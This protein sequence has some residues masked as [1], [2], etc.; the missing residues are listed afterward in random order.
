MRQIVAKLTMS[1]AAGGAPATSPAP[2]PSEVAKAPGRGRVRRVIRL[3]KEE[4]LLVRQHAAA[5]GFSMQRW[6]VALFRMQVRKAPDFGQHELEALGESNYQLLS[7]G[8]NLNQIAKALNSNPGS[9]VAYSDDIIIELRKYIE[10]HAKRVAQ[11]IE[12]STQR[13]M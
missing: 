8:R 6:I 10:R 3:T 12:A 4:D 13:W 7:V 1:T 5:A 2:A 11:L 9:R